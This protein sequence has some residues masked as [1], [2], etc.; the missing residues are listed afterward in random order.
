M[1]ERQQVPHNFLI[2]ERMDEPCFWPAC[3]AH[4]CRENNPVD[5]GDDLHQILGE[6]LAKA[7]FTSGSL[8]ES[9]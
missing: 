1:N 3:L 9:T 2:C 4:G 8:E 7:A 5:V 6:A